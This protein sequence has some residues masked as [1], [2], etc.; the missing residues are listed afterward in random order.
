MKQIEYMVIIKSE[1][2]K[3][4]LKVKT[5]NGHS[6]IMDVVTGQIKHAI[7]FTVWMD[8]WTTYL[9]MMD[10]HQIYEARGGEHLVHKW[11]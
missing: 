8:I 1:N 9:N 5:E 11:L 2:R 10:D 4:L 7:M 3:C 6:E